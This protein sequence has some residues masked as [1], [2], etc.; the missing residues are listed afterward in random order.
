MVHMTANRLLKMFCYWRM[1]NYKMSLFGRYDRVLDT[2]ILEVREI[3][4][5]LP[6]VDMTDFWIFS[7]YCHFERM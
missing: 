5:Y 7:I 1:R 6:L 4:R 3:F 2:G